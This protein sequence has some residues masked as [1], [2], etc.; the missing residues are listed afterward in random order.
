MSC[1]DNIYTDGSVGR[2]AE[3]RRG[4]VHTLNQ[5]TAWTRHWLT[6]RSPF[7]YDHSGGEWAK[8][9]S[10]ALHWGSPE[11]S[12]RSNIQQKLCSVH[13][14]LQSQSCAVSCVHGLCGRVQVWKC[15][16]HLWCHDTVMGSG[17]R[18]NFLQLLQ[19][20][21]HYLLFYHYFWAVNHA[22]LLSWI[23]Q[24]T[25]ESGTYHRTYK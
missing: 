9:R 23:K 14:S 24:K 15:F 11:G 19:K 22:T 13:V 3:L 2:R 6:F 21:K 4:C 1:E 12:G 16:K 20:T 17:F 18:F 5:W 7:Q 8:Q 10:L 25:F